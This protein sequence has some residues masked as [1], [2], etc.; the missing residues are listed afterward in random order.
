MNTALFLK[1]V[2]SLIERLLI[3]VVAYAVTKLQIPEEL[4]AKIN[5]PDMAAWIVALAIPV[6]LSVWYSVHSWLNLKFRELVALRL[7]RGASENDVTEVVAETDVR[8][9]MAQ[10][11]D[12]LAMRNA[13]SEVLMDRREPL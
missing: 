7:P 13:S 4:S 12:A 9:R 10:V 8:S 1:I 3:V 5:I 11:P 6:L 2:R